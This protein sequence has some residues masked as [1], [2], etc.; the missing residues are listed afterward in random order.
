[1][2]AGGP[3]DARH[4]HEIRRAPEGVHADPGGVGVRL[5]GRELEEL[6]A[7]LDGVVVGA[8]CGVHV[9]S[10]AVGV[11]PGPERR[12]GLPGLRV[13]RAGQKEDDES[14]GDC[15][16]HRSRDGPHITAR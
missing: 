14:C 1:M 15:V 7:L 2:I 12:I 6:A 9:H 13:R 11:A 10:G 3:N 16:A 8:A 5:H 4:A